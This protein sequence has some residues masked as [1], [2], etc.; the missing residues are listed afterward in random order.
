M[1]TS[2]IDLL[3]QIRGPAQ[4]R[5]AEAGTSQG[6]KKGWET[7]RG[8]G[9]QT[10]GPSPEQVA[11]AAKRVR[12]YS[13]VPHPPG[14]PPPSGTTARKAWA[15]RA[16]IGASPGQ[17]V[18]DAAAK[19]AKNL[20]Y[21]IRHRTLPGASVPDDSLGRVKMGSGGRIAS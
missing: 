9:G 12:D 8:G 6:A 15:R 10:K 1:L 4:A 16:K 7:R 19:T 20:K 17:K 11:R 21:R 18:A 3:R 2:A 5:F 14:P 13:P